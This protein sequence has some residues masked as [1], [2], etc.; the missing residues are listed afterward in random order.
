MKIYDFL[1]GSKA[2][3]NFSK[4]TERGA[5]P[6]AAIVYCR[7]EYT[8]KSM[9]KLYAAALLCE[10]D[11][12][13][14]LSCSNCQRV[15]KDM[16]PDCQVFPKK[17]NRITV[18]DT[19]KIIEEGSL[20]P[21]EGDRKVFLLMYGESMSPAAQ[22]K[23]LKTLEEPEEPAYIFIGTANI[24][25]LLPTVKSRCALI[26]VELFSPERILSFLSEYCPSG[27]NSIAAYSCGGM[28]G[29]AIEMA[30]S[31]EYLDLYNQVYG[32]LDRLNSSDDVADYC[33]LFSSYRDKQEVLDV[34]QLYF[35][36]LLM[37]KRG[38]DL[39]LNKGAVLESAAATRSERQLI[40]Y[41]E[42]AGEA[43]R[44]LQLNCVPEAVFENIL[45]DIIEEE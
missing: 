39:V 24:D 1:K 11:K 18:E 23:L 3:I 21:C 9:L 15:I 31:S 41:I 42:A 36:D 34:M 4:N 32:M 7:D 14:C 12:K 5:V 26:E 8:L 30:M 28:V 29:K 44:R 19:G 10:S 2:F 20:R 33:R 35:R 13:P 17:G 6:H 38:K 22:N 25:S 16:H 45:I 43:K 37:C 27:N 40:S